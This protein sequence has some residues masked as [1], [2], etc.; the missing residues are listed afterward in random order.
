[1]PLK[2]LIA[3][4]F[5]ETTTLYKTILE[6]RG[7]QITTTKDG[8]ECIKRY[9]SE[10]QSG[11]VRNS[12]PFDIVLVDYAMPNMDGATLVGKILDERPQQRIVFATAHKDQVWNDFKKFNRDVEIIEKPFSVDFLVKGLESKVHLEPKRQIRKGY[13]RNWDGSSGLSADAGPGAN[14]QGHFRNQYRKVG[15]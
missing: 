13:Q 11:R 15:Q 5:P 12:V 8:V 2:I 10:L 9:K 4:D 3:E 6:S 14:S 1:M 7:H